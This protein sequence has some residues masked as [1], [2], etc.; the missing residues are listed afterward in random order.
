MKKKQKYDDENDAPI[1]ATL[2]LLFM[3]LFPITT[4]FI[5]SVVHIKI[6]FEITW[7]SFIVGVILT[8]TAK[9]KYPKNKF[10]KGVF[11]LGIVLSII[12]LWFVYLIAMCSSC[13]G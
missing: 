1:I 6:P 5:N 13:P 3:F 4:P 12:A 10:T 9:I 8:V 11:G 7:L 2:G